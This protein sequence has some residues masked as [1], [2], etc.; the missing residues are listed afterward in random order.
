MF[1]AIFSYCEVPIKNR[2]LLKFWLFGITERVEVGAKVGWIDGVNEGDLVGRMVGFLVGF[3]VVVG[4]EVI[5]GA[6]GGIL[7]MVGQ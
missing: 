4:Y 6:R 7:A 2:K 3:F 1:E 5:D